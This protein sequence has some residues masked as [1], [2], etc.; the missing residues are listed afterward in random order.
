MSQNVLCSTKSLSQMVEFLKDF[1]GGMLIVYGERLK[2][3]QFIMKINNEIT[4]AGMKSLVLDAEGSRGSIGNIP[5]LGSDVY[6][7]D[8]VQTGEDIFNMVQLVQYGHKIVF[9]F[10]GSEITEYIFIRMMV[11]LI[12]FCV[13]DT[14]SN[15]AGSRTPI[16]YADSLAE[17]FSRIAYSKNC[18]FFNANESPLAD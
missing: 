11:R 4:K 5:R 14:G 2:G 10:E 17:L 15:V 8:D 12:G 18:L 6:I 7:F 16:D 13:L 9:T 1:R 3:K